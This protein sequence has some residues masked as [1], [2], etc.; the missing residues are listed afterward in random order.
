MILF[1]AIDIRNG[2][3]VR[4]LRGDYSAETVYS[5]SPL[6]V[7]KEF[8]AVGAKHLHL[9]DLDGARDG[10]LA[11]FSTVSDII[12]GTGMFVEIG[13]GIRD[14]SRVNRYLEAGAGR[15]ILGTAALEDPAFLKDMVRKYGRQIAVGVDARDGFVATH[16]WL[17]TSTVNSIDFCKNLRDTGVSTVIYTDISKDG[18]MQ[19]TNLP[20]YKELCKISGLGVVASGGI[21]SISELRELKDAGVEGAI[22]GRS[23]YTGAVNLGDAVGEFGG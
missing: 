21:S 2:N 11:N 1:P 14:E 3:A 20:V 13:G 19:G 10:E 4:L 23:L 8:S 12:A 7:A 17:R 15:V 5:A 16:G 18:A 6:S 9:V 22:L